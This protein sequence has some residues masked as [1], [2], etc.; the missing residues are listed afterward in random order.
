[1]KSIENPSSVG[2]RNAADYSPFGVQ[3]DGRTQS[4]TQYRY[5][6]Q[7]QEQDD[8][9]KGKGNSVNYKYRMHDPRVGR[10]LSLD[11]LAR[12]YPFNSPFAFAENRVIDGIELEGQEFLTYEE[13]LI[14]MQ[15]GQLFL[16]TE[17]FKDVDFSSEFERVRSYHAYPAEDYTG[18]APAGGSSLKVNKVKAKPIAPEVA[19]PNGSRSPSSHQGVQRTSEQNSNDRIPVTK[20]GKLH[21]SYTYH[22]SPGATRASAALTIAIDVVIQVK[23]HQFVNSLSDYVTK[24]KEQRDD[25]HTEIVEVLDNALNDGFIPSE[26]QNQDG[27]DALYNVILYGGDDDTDAGIKKLGVLLYDYY[28]NDVIIEGGWRDYDSVDGD[29]ADALYINPQS[30]PDN[31]INLGTKSEMYGKSKEKYNML[32]KK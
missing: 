1:M 11:P 14:F 31:S 25:L 22:V 8:E 4:G 16:K 18:M 32:D 27:I 3:L 23:Y 13:A 5:G 12:S 24:I 21:R 26:Y 7:G 9:V 30:L 28:K 19:G 6:F 29:P 10:F 17:N 2:I 15:R 20:K